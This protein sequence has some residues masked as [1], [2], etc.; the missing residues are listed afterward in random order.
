MPHPLN[1][2][3]YRYHMC[4]ALA[5][6]MKGRFPEHAAE[7]D[8]LIQDE[9]AELYIPPAMYTKETYKQQDGENMAALLLQW[10][11]KAAGDVEPGIMRRL[12]PRRAATQAAAALQKQHAAATQVRI[13]A[14]W[15]LAA[16][17]AASP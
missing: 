11:L 1:S 4:R 8:A 3:C 2:I 6:E 16:D 5:A 7:L 15:Q 9:R 12:Q 10:G 13:T 17:I 14:W